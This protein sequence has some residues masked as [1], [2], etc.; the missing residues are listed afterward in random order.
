MEGDD[1][2]ANYAYYCLHKLH[3]RPNQYL[4]MDDQEKAFIIAA[5]RIKLEK[6]KKAAQKAERPKGRRRRRR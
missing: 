2:E 1:P 3:I 5:I 6:E 4:R